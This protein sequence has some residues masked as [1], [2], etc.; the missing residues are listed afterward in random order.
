[1]PD[2]KDVAAAII[3]KGNRVLLARRAKGQALEGAWEFPGGKLEPGETAQAC[4]V[5]ELAEELSMTCIAGDVLTTN[6][7]AYPGGAINLIAVEVRLTSES[8]RL[9]VHDHVEWVAADELM[10]R[11]LAPADVPIAGHVYRLLAG[12]NAEAS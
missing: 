3:M 2:P 11:A 4:V 7:H 9:T 1:M 5:R 10:A 6:L 12:H 8:W